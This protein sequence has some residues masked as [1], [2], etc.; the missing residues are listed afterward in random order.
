EL[1]AVPS[2]CV[3]QARCPLA[4]ERCAQERPQL[5]SVDASRSAACHFSE[6]LDRV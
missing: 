5:V 6:E 4:R 3:F 2:G 1:S